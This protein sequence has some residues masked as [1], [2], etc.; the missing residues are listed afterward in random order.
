[1]DK[2]DGPFS[3]YAYLDSQRLKDTFFSPPKKKRKKKSYQ[4]KKFI[5][6]PAVSVIIILIA[7]AFFF[8]KYDL[9][10]IA[11]QN[12]SEMETNGLSLLHSEIL[13]QLNFVGKDQRLM[14]K[15]NTFIYLT[16]P[17]KEKVALSFD[18]NKPVD[19]NSNSLWL[20]IKKSDTPIKIAV[21][22]KD[23]RFFSNSLNPYII[24]I[25]QNNNSFIKVPIDFKKSNVQNTNLYQIK[26]VTVYFYPQDKEKINWVLLKDLVII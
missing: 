20:Y 14:R 17:S 11:H 23:S 5:L 22:I 13:G 9:M 1:V 25:T 7:M 6:L 4:N 12:P 16:I 18:L 2:R 10:V 19:L 15:A 21:V 26:Q 8:S 3:S 24:E